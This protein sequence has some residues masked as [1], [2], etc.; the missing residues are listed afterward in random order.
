MYLSSK[1]TAV[2]IFCA[3]AFSLFGPSAAI[4]GLLSPASK[5]IG[6]DTFDD[7]NPFDNIN[8]LKNETEKSQI[9]TTSDI[10]KLMETAVSW[11]YEEVPFVEVVDSIREEFGVNVILDRSAE[12]DSLNLDSVVSVKLKNA[13]LATALQ[14]LLDGNNATYVIYDGMLRIISQDVASDRTFFRR[15]IFDCRQLLQKIRNTDSRIGKPVVVRILPVQNYGGSGGSGGF[16]G[17]GGGGGVFNVL[18]TLTQNLGPGAGI[19]SGGM[20]AHLGEESIETRIL[21]TGQ[22]D[23]V[24]GIEQAE[25]APAGS[26]SQQESASNNIQNAVIQTPSAQGMLLDLVRAMVAAESWETT[27]GD[28]TLM[29]VSGLLIVSQSEGVLDDIGVFLRDLE[30]SLSPAEIKK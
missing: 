2:L 29:I 26:A 5:T 24:V 18:P 17:G 10:E 22:V 1:Q 6:S 14:T 30:N 21:R 23:Q 9:K 19:G 25:T 7:T 3:S 15:K 8:T 16:G 28:G 20:R 27:N 13:R 12:D 11:D 4:N